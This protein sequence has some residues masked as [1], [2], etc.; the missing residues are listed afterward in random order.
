MR[1]HLLP[2]APRWG[3]PVAPPPSALLPGT[4]TLASSW[5]RGF[6]SSLSQWKDITVPVPAMGESITEATVATLLKQPGDVVLEDEVL[7]QLETD[8]VT[9]D[10]KYQEKVP[11]VVK[12][13]LVGEGD[14]VV[15]G[16]P[17]AVIEENADAGA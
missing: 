16:Q 9:I 12:E 4:E 2:Q 15:V 11:G 1:L 14:T 13:L 5:L 3:A 17:F 10:L 8:K 6:R 7:A